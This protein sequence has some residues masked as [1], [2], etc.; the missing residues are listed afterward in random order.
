MPDYL[1]SDRKTHSETI[2]SLGYAWQKDIVL[3]SLFN[4]DAGIYYPTLQTT[5]GSSSLLFSIDACAV[6]SVP[7]NKLHY[8]SDLTKRRGVR[9]D[10]SSLGPLKLSRSPS[11]L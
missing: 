2:R 10:L 5:R 7:A 1:S 8:R 3:L 9:P 6:R 11:D 4:S